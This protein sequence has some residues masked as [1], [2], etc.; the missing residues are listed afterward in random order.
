MNKYYAYYSQDGI[1]WTQYN[2]NLLSISNYF[3]NNQFFLV[4][5]DFND[6]KKIYITA[7]G[8]SWKIVKPNVSIGS[9]RFFHKN[10]Y[11]STYNNALYVSKN[12]IEWKAIPLSLVHTVYSMLIYDN[13][14]MLSTNNGIFIETFSIISGKLKLSND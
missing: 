1:N 7:D 10:T 11:Y 8:L 3:L 12:L 2:Y 14:L 13:K 4:G 6:I 9:I 5:S